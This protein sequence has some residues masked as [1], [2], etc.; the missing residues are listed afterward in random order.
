MVFAIKAP[1]AGKWWATSKK[2]GKVQQE[3]QEVKPSTPP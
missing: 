3:P 1:M 2:T